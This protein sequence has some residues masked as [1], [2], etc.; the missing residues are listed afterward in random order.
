[1]VTE[2]SNETKGVV[3]KIISLL[4]FATAPAQQLSLISTLISLIQSGLK[5]KDCW[6]V[7]EA[8]MIGCRA[9]WRLATVK[10]AANPAEWGTVCAMLGDIQDI[11]VTIVIE[12]HLILMRENDFSISSISSIADDEVSP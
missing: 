3:G 5:K 2:I 7:Y 8:D 4:G 9:R 1:M 11:L 6:E 12:E 10:Y